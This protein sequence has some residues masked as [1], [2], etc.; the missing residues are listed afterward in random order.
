MS[1]KR[2]VLDIET[3]NHL[4]NMIDFNQQPLKL[5]KEA[6]LWCIV[7]TNL[8]NLNQSLVYTL[9]E[10]NRNNI[11]QALKDVELVIGHNIV[12][13]D[14]PALQLFGVIDYT[15]GYLG[16]SH[17]LFGK[18]VDFKDT[19]VISQLLNPD[20]YGG[21]SLAN[22]SKYNEQSKTEHEDFSEFSLEMVEYC[23]NDTR[24]NAQVYFDLIKEMGS[25]DYSKSLAQETK[26]VDLTLKQSM[27]GFN[28]NE[29]LAKECLVD[30][31]QKLLN[32][33]EKVDPILPPKPLNKGERDSYTPPKTQLKKD[34]SFSAHMI[35]FAEKV[36]AVLDE[37][38]CTL[39]INGKT[40][41]I[42]FHEPIIDSIKAD[43]DDLDH[44]KSYLL[45]LGWKPS[46]WKERDLSKD[47][48]KMKLSEE[49]LIPTIQRYVESTLN[50][51]YR[52]ARLKLLDVAPLELEEYLIN[53]YSGKGFSNFKV[54]VSPC[55]RVG[56]SKELCPN[57]ELLGN[58]A[59]FA[60]DVT[61]YLT[62]KHRRNS[63][64]GG[65]EEEDGTPTTGY[66]SL[67]RSNGR[68]GTPAF[69]IGAASFR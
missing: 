54:P 11:Q 40:F 4:E 28:F 46:E 64:A 14:L 22:L 31:D 38:A 42:P 58:K 66:L 10:C 7:I 6:N 8:D 25:W 44:L 39:S 56:T 26:L 27:F 43:I 45:T 5:K 3:N 68:I 23:I 57:L 62:Y 21:H 30:L 67:V 2:V 19:L 1:F 37:E 33:K 47:S 69:T 35:K 60:K 24:S 65:T 12:G 59:D 20:R 16:Q 41:N 17:T 9:Q 53:K 50:G 15:I 61:E 48:K 55:I 18:P 32:I 52:E 63:I 29:K 34:L 13:F 36:G 51:P 49:K